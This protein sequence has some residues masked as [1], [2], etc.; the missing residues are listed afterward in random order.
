MRYLSLLAACAVV[1]LAVV[2]TGAGARAEHVTIHIDD[3]FQDGRLTAACGF[4]V[5]IDFVGE[6][7]VTLIRNKEGLIVRELDHVGGGAKVTY[8]SAQASF[9]FPFDTSNW[10]YGEGAK[11]GSEVIVSAHGLFGH[12]PGFIPSDAGLFR[13]RG[14]VTGFDEFGI[15]LVDFVEVIAD[16]GNRE[17]ADDVAAAICEALS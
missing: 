2:G 16:R 6:A 15:P 9:S 11:V 3:H 10:D 8:R 12:V 13:F 7:K 5:F 14:V 4:A 1:A 17:S